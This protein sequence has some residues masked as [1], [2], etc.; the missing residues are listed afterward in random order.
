M[1][2]SRFFGGH[3]LEL[4]I[5]RTRLSVADF[6]KSYRDRKSAEIL[7]QL[8]A[9]TRGNVIAEFVVNAEGRVE[10][11][12]LGII[13]STH[14]L[15]ADAVRRAVAVAIFTPALRAGKPV[16]QLVHQPFEF[17]AVK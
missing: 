14:P 16:R 9:H 12:T 5:Q 13:S 3:R 8:A 6:A 4:S 11:G 17:T 10:P 15:F 7:R 2:R 1:V